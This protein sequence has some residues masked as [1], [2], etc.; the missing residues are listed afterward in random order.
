MDSIRMYLDLIYDD[1]QTVLF[2]DEILNDFAGSYI[3]FDHELVPQAGDIVNLEKA[4]IHNAPNYWYKKDSEEYHATLAVL[5]R[6]WKVD[7]I[8]FSGNCIIIHLVFNTNHNNAMKIMLP[9]Y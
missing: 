9:K 3:V 8:E 4:E 5:R 6:D 2:D 1:D 7:Y